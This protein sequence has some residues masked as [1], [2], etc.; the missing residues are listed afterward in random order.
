MAVLIL[1]CCC[2]GLA[3]LVLLFPSL[4]IVVLLVALNLTPEMIFV[5]PDR[6]EADWALTI[7]LD[8]RAGAGFRR[9][10]SNCFRQKLGVPAHLSFP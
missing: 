4:V 6:E 2:L 7:D 9:H 8:G 10:S 3:L 1:S 5:G